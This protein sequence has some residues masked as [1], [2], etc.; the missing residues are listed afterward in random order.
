MSKNK[1]KT[2]SAASS[3]ARDRRFVSRVLSLPRP[4]RILLAALP[5]VALVAL[6]QPM[7]DL[8]Y[9][10]LFFS[11]STVQLP[12]WILAAFGLIM[13]FAGW[14]F[15]VGLPGDDMTQKRGAVLYLSLSI[16]I[17]ALLMIY[18]ALQIIDNVE[19]FAG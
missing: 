3:P 13:Y 9:L 4:T 17:I 7:I 5:A 6:L 8:I 18:Y 2:A 15:L 10:R 11:E 19:A 16:L 1:T 14:M 12:A